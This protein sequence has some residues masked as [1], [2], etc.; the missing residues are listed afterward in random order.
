MKTNRKS[1]GFTL[2][3]LLVVIAIIAILASILLPVLARGKM[4]AKEINCINNLKQVGLG[5]R[6]W[7]GD[8]GEKYPWNVDTSLGG[9]KGAV[10]WTDNFRVCSNELRA[11]QILL[12]PLDLKKWS[13][14]NWTTMR[15]DVNVSFFIGMSTTGARTQDIVAGDRNV[16][17]GGGGLDP[18]WSTFLG[19]SIDAAWDQTMHQLK[20]DLVMGDGSARKFNTQNLRDQIV[21]LLSTGTTNVIFSKPRGIF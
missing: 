14:T 12:C 11:T 1:R 19:T 10:D 2:I 9:S 3:E 7:A 16:I 18:S 8:N 20:G 17:G 6:L 13:A 5:I 21:L 4:K 15:G